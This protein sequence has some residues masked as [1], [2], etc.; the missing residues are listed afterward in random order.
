[1][2]LVLVSVED[3]FKGREVL[4]FDFLICGALPSVEARLFRET[5][6]FKIEFALFALC[7]PLSTFSVLVDSLSSSMDASS[8][9]GAS[10]L[11][12]TSFNLVTLLG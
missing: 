7:R 4:A 1:M 2:T 8:K 10:V 9:T 6:A 11:S 3:V 12:T 5:D